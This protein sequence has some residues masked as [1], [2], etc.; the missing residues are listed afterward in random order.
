[1]MSND[2]NAENANTV[3]VIPPE[4]LQETFGVLD[5]ETEVT[6]ASVVSL[7]K[8]RPGIEMP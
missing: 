5:E 8:S 1:M 2:K 7:R 4:K 6:I 3:L